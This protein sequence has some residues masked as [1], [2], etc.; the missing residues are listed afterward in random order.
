M[1]NKKLVPKKPDQESSRILH[2]DTA[3]SPAIL[4]IYSKDFEVLENNLTELALAA[5]IDEE[6]GKIG[7]H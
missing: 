3:G 2:T 7:Q 5:F 4:G 6:K 1:R